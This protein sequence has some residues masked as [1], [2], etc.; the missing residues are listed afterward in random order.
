MSSTRARTMLIALLL[1]A[2]GALGA[3]GGGDDS[4]AEKDS[5]PTRPE[6][7][8]QVDKL[9]A[10]VTKASQPTNR[11][12]QALVNGTGTFSSRLKKS[13]PLLQKT[14]D[15]QKGKLEDVRAVPSPKK[16]RAQINEVLAT[17]SKALEEFKKGIPIARRGDL[18]NFID[19][20]FDA[21]GTRAKAERLGTTYGFA[22]DC[23]RIPIELDELS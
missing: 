6:Y 16:D 15:L 23:F 22:A 11:K 20:A 8:A 14:Y 19:I 7:I 9:C 5:G 21:N 13:T 18:K 4:A 3:C 1:T 12:L 10:K 17:G 2:A